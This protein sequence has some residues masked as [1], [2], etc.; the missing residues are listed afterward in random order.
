MFTLLSAYYESNTQSY[1]RKGVPDCAAPKTRLAWG[2]EDELA[3]RW[4]LI[5]L[6]YY[7]VIQ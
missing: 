7:Q 3:L 1:S 2:S 6:I 4:N 5:A